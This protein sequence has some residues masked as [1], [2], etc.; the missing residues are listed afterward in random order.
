MRLRHQITVLL[1]AATLGLSGLAHAAEKED[2]KTNTEENADKNVKIKY[3]KRT[4]VDFGAQNIEGKLRRPETA[5]IEAS[6]S[7]NDQGVLRL[8]ENFLDKIASFSGEDVK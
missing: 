3:K 6:E 4:Q 5:L 7:V 2:A 8:R 1:T